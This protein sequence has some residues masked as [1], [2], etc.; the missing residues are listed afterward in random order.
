[1]QLKTF[2]IIPLLFLSCT[3]Q[4]ESKLVQ[5]K[6]GVKLID[7]NATFGT[8][9]LF[10]N[11]KNN[12]ESKIIF[13]HHHSTAY[14]IG[15]RGEIDKSDVKDVTGSYPGVIG[16]DFADLNFNPEEQPNWLENN[17]IRAYDNGLINIFAW[18]LD[19]LVT[20]KNFYDT[21]IVVKHILPGGSHH[22]IYK[23]E[24]D[25]IAYFSKHIIGKDGKLIPIIFRPFHEFD[26]SW[27]WWGEHFCTPEE[28]IALWQFTIKYL[29]DEQK[30][31]NILYAFSPDCKYT[32]EYDFLERYPGDEYVDIIGMDNYWDFTP[33]GEGLIAVKEKL[34]LVS[35]IAKE[36][37]KIAAFTETGLEKISDEK[38]WTD[39]L[40]KVIKNDS[41]NIAFVMVWR[42]AHLDHFYVP[43]KNHPSSGNFIEFKNDPKIIFA[44]EL[45]D[46]YNLG[47]ILSY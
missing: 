30:V 26:G 1:M 21:T 13:G 33:L 23:R 24:L 35:K 19:N 46:L 47:K 4:N 27:F 12:P 40:L 38:W 17:V 44:D 2:V 28:Y 8:V 14:G 10:Y 15:W 41:I 6:L 34:K 5:Q 16:W 7:S 45:P 3:Y 11:L 36:R 31:K 20:G 29:R 9:A 39:K 43:F 25:R 37:N 22:E 42:N 32:N 18:H